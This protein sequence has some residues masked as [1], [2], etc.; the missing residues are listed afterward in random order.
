M[1]SWEESS[2]W[3]L[4]M[5]TVQCIMYVHVCVWKSY[6][7]SSVDCSAHSCHVW[8]NQKGSLE[9]CKCLSFF[10]KGGQCHESSGILTRVSQDWIIATTVSNSVSVVLVLSRVKDRIIHYNCYYNGIWRSLHSKAYCQYYNLIVK[11][12]IIKKG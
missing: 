10:P 5:C 1:I 4:Y 11:Q 7:V 12:S 8:I 3:I 9:I 2:L 6:T